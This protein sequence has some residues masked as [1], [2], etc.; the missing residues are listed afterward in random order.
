MLLTI[1]M[2]VKNE[3]KHLAECLSSLESIRE[4]L[5][6]ELVIVDTGSDDNTVEI[7]KEYTDKVYFHEWNDN[8]SEMRNTVIDYANGDWFFTLD[9]DEVVSNPKTIIDFFKSGNYKE[10]KT[11]FVTQKNYTNL[12]ENRFSKILQARLFETKDFHYKGAVHNQPQYKKPVYELDTI[13][14]HY[15][16]VS[17]DEDLIEKKFKRTSNILKQELEKDPTNVYYWFQLSKS[18]NM[19]KDQEDAL[20]AI[21]EAY[22]VAQEND[23]D[24]SIRMYVLIQLAKMYLINNRYKMA[25]KIVENALDIKDGYVD[26]YYYLARAQLL[27]GKKEEGLSNFKEYIKLINNYDQ[28]N[29][30]IDTSVD[31]ETMGNYNIAYRFIIALAADLEIETDYAIEAA[32]KIDV[33]S[34]LQHAIHPFISI[35]LN[36]RRHMELKKFY[37]EQLENKN[38][39]T[40]FINLLEKLKSNLIIEE[41]EKVNS[42]FTDLEDNREYSLLNKVRENIYQESYQVNIEQLVDI[43]YNTKPDYYGDIVYYLLK[44]NNNDT[45]YKLLTNIREENLNRFISYL[46]DKYDDLSDV[47]MSFVDLDVKGIAEARVNKSLSRYLLALDNEV[48]KTNKTIIENYL[49]AGKKYIEKLYTKEIIKN[50]LIYELKSEE[51]AFLLYMY[52]AFEVKEDDLKIYIQYLRKAI[53]IYP[54]MKKVVE[55]LMLEVKEEQ[56][57][58]NKM[59]EIKDDIKSKVETMISNNNLI[60]AE[61]TLTEYQQRF[62]IDEDIYSMKSIILINKG[63]LEEA[64]EVLIKGLEIYPNNFDLNF[65]LSF[66]YE[67]LD[68]LERSIVQYHRAEELAKN[69]V[70]IQEV[71]KSLNRIKTNNKSADISKKE[72]VVFFCKKGLDNFIDDLIKGLSDFYETKKVIVNKYDQIDK[73]IEWSDIVWF[74][75]CDE[76]VIY[77]SKL[78]LARDKK[79]VCRLHSYEAF[80]NYISKVNWSNIDRIIFVA[81]HIR[82]FVLNQLQGIN[83]KNKSVI[84]PNGLNANKFNYRRRKHG[85]NLA[86][87]GLINYKKGPML[88]LQLIKALADI[89]KKYKLFIAGKFEQ[90]RYSLYFKQ[91]IKDMNLQENVYFEGWQDDIDKWL[92]N[93]NYIISSSVLESQHLSIMEAMSKGIKPIV[94]NFVGAKNIYPEK[95]I[96]NS[97]NQG[98]ELIRNS[99]YSSMEYKKFIQNNYS[100]KKQI[101]KTKSLLEKINKE[102][103]KHEFDY[104]SYWNMRLNNKFDIE[105]VGYIG[106]GKIYNKYLYNIRF[107]IL[108]HIVNKSFISLKNKDIL[109]LGPGIGIFTDYF[110]KSNVGKYRGI[111]IAKKS[112]VELSKKYKEFNF[113][114]GDISNPD[115]FGDSKYDLIFAA[116]VLLHQTNE[117]KYNATIKNIY[118]S[119]KDNGIVILFDPISVIGTKS[120]SEHVI[121]RDIEYIKK[122]LNKNGLDLFALLPTSFFMNNPFDANLLEENKA[123]VINLFKYINNIFG[124]SNLPLKSKEILAKWLSMLER[125]CLVSKGFGL[126]QKVLIITKN[127]KDDIFKEQNINIENIWDINNIEANIIKNKNILANDNY[128]NKDNL[129]LKFEK[130]INPII[131]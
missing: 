59:E 50:E 5:D 102:N 111:D 100:L 4:E 122:I 82:E 52:K 87:V 60:G 26:L 36:N 112:I 129:I 103:S 121:I 98:I 83:I 125:K 30:K 76:L 62:K 118:S 96:W 117:K 41:K 27:Q 57:K 15:G 63:F 29:S 6:S 1:G 38:L 14:E 47:M 21:E 97:I 124:G 89:N 9:G 66:V 39:K 114:H 127:G 101:S 67:N 45:T 70:E 119:L 93:K 40:K 44:I 74:E 92:E 46:N 7:A 72:K 61:K 35:C 49:S 99:D 116:D 85:Y 130:L 128:I 16:Y 23:L 123:D 22:K 53:D 113:I 37:L 78:D 108:K 25:E 73:W 17:S 24:L 131:T 105:G 13:L 110:F 31:D 106:L 79:M 8:F 120:K 11:V 69:K 64:K 18:Y 86:Y 91:M 34:Q 3:E 95:Y 54:L 12:E 109:E 71:E 55:T 42:L 56:G 58:I 32:F 51:E 80:T 75:W 107:D 77:G 43:N 28:T 65:N 19:H 94:H 10:Y 68:K 84:I 88:A 115:N 2:M 126:S 90:A 48:E 81:E 33:N 104:N 20:D